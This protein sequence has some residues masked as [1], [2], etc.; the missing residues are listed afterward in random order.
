MKTANDIVDA[1][2][3]DAICAKL[4][5]ESSAVSNAC[6]RGHFP[7]SWYLPMKALAIAAKKDLPDEL[8]RWRGV[9]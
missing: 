8:F 9:V 1:L 5:V 6:T 7:T 3:R 4:E 2:G